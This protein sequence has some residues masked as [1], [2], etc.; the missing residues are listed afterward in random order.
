MGLYEQIKAGVIKVHNYSPAEHRFWKRV[1]KNGPPHQALGECWQWE[2]CL[3]SKGYAVLSIRGK[4]T[5]AYRFS[6]EIHCGSI[7]DGLCAC[8]HCDNPRCVNPAHLFIGTKA[9]NTADCVRKNRHAKGEKQFKSRL[10]EDHVREIRRLFRKRSTT[11]GRA[12]LAKR[13]GVAKITITRV[14]HGDNW[15]HV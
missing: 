14:V 12:A 2:G 6:W 13:F 4:Q 8:H 3:D 10:T 5:M 7:P 9:D 15:S 1:N 11:V